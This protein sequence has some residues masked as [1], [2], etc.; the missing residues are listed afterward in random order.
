[1]SKSLQKTANM[2]PKGPSE[3]GA[4]LGL[5]IPIIAGLSATL[6]LGVIDTIMVSPLGTVPLAAISLAAT[7]LIIIYSGLYGFLSPI[8]VEAAQRY[9]QGD[10]AG[11]R[12]LLKGG[13]SMA[14]IAGITAAAIF[15]VSYFLL[16]LFRQPPEV[17]AE[18][19]GY[20]FMVS[21]VL[22]S[23]AAL[24]AISFVLNAIDRAWTAACFAFF[25][26]LVN[27]PLNYV[28]IWGIG[29][30]PGL[31]LFG[32]GVATVIA[33][34]LALAV[35]LGWL[36]RNGF[37][38][39]ET[40]SGLRSQMA[41]EGMPLTIA[42]VGEGAAY[43]VVGLLLGLFGAA[44]LAANQIVQSIAGVL[45]M[46]PIGMATATTVRIG[47]AI[48][49]NARSR[50]R[51]IARTAMI[52][53]AGW[54]LCVTVALLLTGRHISNALSDDPQVIGIAVA[55]FVVVAL[56]QVADGIQSTALGA[57]R[58]A[59]D[60]VWPTGFTL[61]CYWLFALPLGYTLGIILD[62]GPL[63]LWAGYGTGIILAAIV[64]PIR[65]WRLT[66]AGARP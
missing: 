3:A 20:W 12:R 18:V 43:S 26:V 1:M 35:A 58:G 61:A 50:L 66:G 30:W 40:E 46:L 33:D 45:Y 21:L 36:R 13:L 63:G 47:Q 53:V 64:L 17:I 56:I 51:P 10:H 29:G 14:G 62:F 32:A 48:G 41:T 4:L 5:S 23:V 59:K 52:I 49:A 8:G 6:L 60:F 28:M 57:L 7:V 15:A 34:G 9:G 55:M 16:P 24:M 38:K 65:F 31:G 42:Y 19:R 44:A 11:V 39:Q 22:M 25:G 27:V 37:L 2:A 54:M